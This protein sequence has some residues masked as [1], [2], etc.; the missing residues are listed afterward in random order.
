MKPL[1][2]RGGHI[3]DPSQGIDLSCDILIENGRVAWLDK[4]GRAPLSESCLVLNA[5]GMLVTPGF[6]DI[7]TH[8]REPGFEEKETIATG[9]FAAARGGFTTICCMPNTNP[10]IDSRAVIDYVKGKAEKEGVIRVLPI[11]CVTKG[12][13]GGELADLGELARAGVVGYSDDGEPVRDSNLMRHALEYSRTFALPIIDHCEDTSLTE[14]GAMN[15]GLVAT[16]LGLV[17]I[18]SQAEEIM[19]FRDIAL[20]ELTGG[21]V[22]IAHISTRG[23]VE[24]IRQAKEKGINVTAEVTPHHLTMT[25]ERV[26]GNKESPHP[27]SL[28]PN[29]KVKP[30]LRTGMDIEALIEGLKDG[31]IDA[32][33]TDHAPHTIADKMCEFNLASFGI[34]G[35]ETAFGSLMG[36]VHSG[37]LDLAMLISKLTIEPAKIISAALGT[38][39]VGSPGDVVIFDPNLEWVVDPASFASKGKNNPLAG[40]LLKGKA[41]ATVYG[42]EVVYKDDHLRM[43]M[44]PSFKEGV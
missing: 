40:C 10:P 22:H 25:E 37:K 34:S 13:K 31:T 9:T 18:P 23:S 4:A 39:K 17:G 28:D 21:R 5:R 27:L 6:V 32:I 2:I 3:L 26:L 41:M 15:E 7:H 12:R 8:L 16:R 20:A 36:L 14:G 29:A 24:L 19:V 30:P 33:A 1:L 42:G 35:L 38:L 43:E 11:G 44:T